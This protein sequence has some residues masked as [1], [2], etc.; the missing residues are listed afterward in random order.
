M[1]RKVSVAPLA[2]GQSIALFATSDRLDDWK[3]AH[4]TT[5]TSVSVNVSL[6]VSEQFIKCHIRQLSAHDTRIRAITDKLAGSESTSTLTERIE[7]EGDMLSR[8]IM[9]LH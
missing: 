2:S 4:S 3:K 7:H 6:S 5:G 9:I 8:L 1:H